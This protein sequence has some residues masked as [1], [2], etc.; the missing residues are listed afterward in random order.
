MQILD[1][2]L[3]ELFFKENLLELV[4][5]Q[6]ILKA[7]TLAPSGN[8]RNIAPFLRLYLRSPS[9]LSES[10]IY[11]KFLGKVFLPPPAQPPPHSARTAQ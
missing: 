3:L 4:G 9:A 10:I 5:I 11:E 8:D 7:V 1:G 2:I 6:I